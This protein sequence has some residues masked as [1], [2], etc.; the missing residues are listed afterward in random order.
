MAG[1]GDES[2]NG[3]RNE[4]TEP[5]KAGVCNDKIR[6]DG[7]KNIIK[8]RNASANDEVAKGV[9]FGF[10]LI[11]IIYYNTII[12]SILVRASL[13]FIGTKLLYFLAGLV[14]LIFLQ[15]TVRWSLTF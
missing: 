2:G 6:E 9:V 8:N 3:S 14:L 1:E 13:L 12:Y 5:E 7:I 4:R 11:H 10:L 15:N